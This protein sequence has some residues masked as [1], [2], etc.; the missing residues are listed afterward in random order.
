MV[1]TARLDLPPPAL[2]GAWFLDGLSGLAG[3]S[4]Q[5]L[6]TEPRRRRLCW[7]E[8]LS[9][10]DPAMVIYAHDALSRFA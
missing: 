8:L 5:G 4:G 6:V 7:C 9:R 2:A 3:A 10:S 1:I